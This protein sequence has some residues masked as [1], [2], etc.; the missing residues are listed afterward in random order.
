MDGEKDGGVMNNGGQL[1]VLT[2][3]YLILDQKLR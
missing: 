1:E 2:E 3:A